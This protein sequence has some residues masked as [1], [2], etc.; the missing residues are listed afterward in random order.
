M[1]GLTYTPGDL[2]KVAKTGPSH[3]R[4][5]RRIT[6]SIG[7][8]HGPRCASLWSPVAPSARSNV[9]RELCTDRLSLLWHRAGVLNTGMAERQ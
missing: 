7:T 6:P 1:E 2:A 4:W 5:S 9:R 8:R 3:A